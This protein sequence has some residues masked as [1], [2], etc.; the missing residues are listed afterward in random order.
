MSDTYWLLD[1]GSDGD[2]I[3][4]D[5]VLG[6]QP[7]PSPER[8][9]TTTLQCVFWPDLVDYSTLSEPA[10]T[11]QQTRFDA[12]TQYLEYVGSVSTLQATDGSV[13][14]RESVPS[15][16]PVATFF[17]EVV[18]PSSAATDPFYAVVTGGST[19]AESTADRRRLDLTLTY[20]GDVADYASRSDARDALEA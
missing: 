17:V 6:T 12:A 20:L 15:A 11:G 13:F 5:E 14:F 7:L 19:V 9:A 8:G 16:S 4:I 1:R 2:D 3:P 18:P 10:L